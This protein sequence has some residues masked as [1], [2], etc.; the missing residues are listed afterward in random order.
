MVKLKRAN[1]TIVE[2]I[3]A[4]INSHQNNWEE[5]LPL[6]EIAYN[7]SIQ[8]STGYSPYYLNTGR[9]FPNLIAR[10]M[11]N[12]ESISNPAV[13]KTIQQWAEALESAKET[14]EKAQENQQFWANKHRRELTFDVGSK[15]LLST[16]NIRSG[17]IGASKFLPRFI[18]P[19]LI[20]RVISSTAYELDLPSTMH[21]HPV[22]HINLLKP[23]IDGKSLFPNRILDPNTIRP[24]PEM[25]S[26]DDGITAEPEWVVEDII[27]KRI[28]R[29]HEEYLVRWKGYPLEESTWEPIDNLY[30][31]LDLVGKFN[32]YRQNT[33]D[34]TG[35]RQRRRRN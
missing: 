20:K 27:E 11:E 1:R 24:P 26:S 10:A 17:M 35:L 28:R 2:M 34:T 21:I 32:M 3:R 18:G 22:F 29:Q 6:L 7:S 9:E 13:V 14:I 16:E 8:M 23:Y 5:L 15:V 31:A 4:F 33:N 19:Y 25:I 12:I 30:N